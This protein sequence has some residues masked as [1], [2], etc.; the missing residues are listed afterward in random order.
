MRI[1]NVPMEVD[2]ESMNMGDAVDYL[3]LVLEIYGPPCDWCE[4]YDYKCQEGNRPRTYLLEA[5]PFEK[6]TMKKHC[7]DF[8]EEPVEKA[9]QESK[10]VS[11]ILNCNAQQYGRI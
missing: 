8:V 6:W 11:N 7:K 10:M 3:N 1:P 5:G 2:I 4:H 9:K